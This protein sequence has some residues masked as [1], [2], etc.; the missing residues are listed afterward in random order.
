MAGN[1]NDQLNEAQKQAVSA[2][3]DKALKIIA[4][5]GTGK[6]YTMV[7][8]FLALSKV[9]PPNQ[10]LALTFTN[11]AAEEMLLRLEAEG[12]KR[13]NLWVFTFHSFAAK[14]MRE[15]P[16]MVDL[17]A[18]FRIIE[19]NE[20]ELLLRRSLTKLRIEKHDLLERIENLYPDLLDKLWVDLPSVIKRIKLHLLHPGDF[21][22][23]VMKLSKRISPLVKFHEKESELEKMIGE[24]VEAYYWLYQRELAQ[25]NMLDFSDLLIKLY[26]LLQNESYRERLAKR[27][28]YIL[29][30]EFQDTNIAQFKILKLLAQPDMSNVSIVG[31]DKQ[32]I[33]GFRDAD[34]A[35]LTKRFPPAQEVLLKVNYR[36]FQPILDISNQLL[37]R[38]YSRQIEEISAH[39]GDGTSI[40]IAFFVGENE[41]EEAEFIARKI[42]ELLGKPL[43]TKNKLMN[44]KEG[45]PINY[46]DFA[47]LMRA[48][49]GRKRVQYLEEALNRWQ[50]P[51]RIVGGAAFLGSQEAIDILNYLKVVE[52]PLDDISMSA[53]LCNP[54]LALTD[55]Q[56][57]MLRQQH[58][59]SELYDDSLYAC[60]AFTEKLQSNL[61]SETMSRLKEFY[62]FL[63]RMISIKDSVSLASLVSSAI[64][65]S[66]YL[67]YIKG[68]MS[69]QTQMRLANLQRL[70]RLA[71]DFDERQIF[72]CL[73]DFIDYIDMIQE[74][75]LDER[76]IELAPTEEAVSIM[77]IHK[78]KGLEFPVVFMTDFPPQK[79]RRP[80]YRQLYFDEKYGLLLKG[81]KGVETGKFQYF[82][83]DNDPQQKEIE[84][85]E[86]VKYVGLTRAQELLVLTA[87]DSDNPDI[88][89]IRDFCSK[90]HP[91]AQ[92]V[93]MPE[94]PTIQKTSGIK[95]K[96]PLDSREREVVVQRLK[97]LVA[98][99]KERIPLSEE[100][101][102]L[103]FSYSQLAVY[104]NCP[105]Q[106]YFIY[107][108]RL[109]RPEELFQD[110]LSPPQQELSSGLNIQGLS[111]GTLMHKVLSQFHRSPPPVSPE[112]RWQKLKETM[113]TLLLEKG[114]GKRFPA[115]IEK[116]LQAYAY[117]PYSE[118]HP[119]F[120]DREFNLKLNMGK[121]SFINLRGFIDRIDKVDSTWKIIDYKTD[122]QLT[123]HKIE[124]YRFQLLSYLLAINRGALLPHITMKD[125][126]EIE[127]LHVQKGEVI[128]LPYADSDVLDTEKNIIQLAHRI[129]A[130]DFAIREE[131]KERDCRSCSFGGDVG[132]CPYN[133]CKD[134]IGKTS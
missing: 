6:T 37:S 17:D 120:I 119:A 25:N 4:G 77:T 128:P 15:S 24:L 1:S 70:H 63:N 129:I 62:S 10:I 109:P 42:R 125:R 49:R 89:W 121:D 96:G 113:Q 84:E 5:P 30:D 12:L 11:K 58:I 53:V 114:I 83:Q 2:S 29:V 115:Q 61:S 91:F 104:S 117:H 72:C 8:R 90:N 67:R 44:R 95:A 111:Y 16:F 64:E 68:G 18:G 56:I 132:F 98:L 51:Y 133:R 14:L 47:I 73:K 81:E 33:Y 20:Q 127:V 87:V 22:K 38:H 40:S 85:E 27:F 48:M 118:I 134:E 3:T 108:L 13:Q 123:S 28:R 46:G 79:Q 36:S 74:L 7:K 50:I 107:I 126:V 69:Y 26:N 39:H 110:A 101:V 19:E 31:D 76:D 54:C 86:R 100:I 103:S 55:N 82:L 52:N 80:K 41:E 105:L 32:S 57:Y 9:F 130:R 124:M 59:D 122:A 116:V 60:L 23:N 99:E 93:N 102:Q 75:G 66:G 78:G 97:K 88:S 43:R 106:Y 92:E 21:A 65:G 34:M 35:N 131:H 112:E 45:E 94:A 71:K